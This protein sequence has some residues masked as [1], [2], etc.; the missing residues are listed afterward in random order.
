MEGYHNYIDI[1]FS[2]AVGQPCTLIRSSGEQSYACSNR[3][4]I[5]GLCRD[6]ETKTNFVNEAQFLLISEESVNDLNTRLRSSM[7]LSIIFLVPLIYD[8][9]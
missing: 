7:F 4:K 3:N 1:W 2:N 9:Q 6:L 5:S 8:V